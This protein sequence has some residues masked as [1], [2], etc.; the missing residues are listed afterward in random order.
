M[1]LGVVEQTAI[2][3]GFVGPVALVALTL[4]GGVLAQ[5]AAGWLH[6]HSLSAALDPQTLE[7]SLGFV[8]RQEKTLMAI[9]RP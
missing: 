3:G 8:G 7:Q 2:T 9:A 1:A 5:G 6:A 4:V